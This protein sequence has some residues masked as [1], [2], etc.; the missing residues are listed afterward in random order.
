MILIFAF[1]LPSIFVFGHH[2]L[3]HQA[4]DLPPNK[5]ALEIATAL[6][7]VESD[8]ERAWACRQI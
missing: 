1:V 8:E 3:Q 6:I 2:H 5:L 7:T 4:S